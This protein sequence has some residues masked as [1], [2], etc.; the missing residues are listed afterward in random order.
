MS[1]RSSITA[2]AAARRETI[3]SRIALVGTV[4]LHWLGLGHAEIY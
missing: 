4:G 1:A 3:M 2:P